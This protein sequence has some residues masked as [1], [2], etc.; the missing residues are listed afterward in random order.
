[1]K[2]DVRGVSLYASYSKVPALDAKEK[3]GWSR[4]EQRKNNAQGH[5]TRAKDLVFL[6]LT[7]KETY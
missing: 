1:L 6:W 7:G 2:E 5:I 4:Q 3:I